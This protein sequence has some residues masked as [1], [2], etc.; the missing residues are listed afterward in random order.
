MHGETI[1]L[2]VR[3]PPP[4]LRPVEV[5]VVER[6]VDSNRVPPAWLTAS[7]VATKVM[8]GTITSSPGSESLAERQP[9]RVES[10]RVATQWAAPQ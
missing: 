6:D 3:P 7:K 9:E 8:A 10:A 2:F 4:R 5:V 1:A